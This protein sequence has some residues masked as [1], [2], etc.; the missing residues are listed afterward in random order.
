VLRT[1]ALLLT[2]GRKTHC[3]ILFPQIKQ[4]MEAATRQ[5]EERKKQLSFISPPTPQVP[6]GSTGQI[7]WSPF[8][9]LTGCAGTDT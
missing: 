9:L 7:P 3:L 5:I 4:M 6:A 1:P 8:Q 2:E